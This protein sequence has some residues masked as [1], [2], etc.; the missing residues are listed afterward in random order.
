MAPAFGWL[1]W[2]NP[3]YYAFENLFTNEFS[4]L[5]LQCASPVPNVAGISEAF[6]SCAIRGAKPGKLSIDG[7]EYTNA[8]GFLLS[9]RWRNIGVLILISIVYLLVGIF[10]SEVM[11][12]TAGSPTITFVTHKQKKKKDDS[13][14]YND[15]EKSAMSS[16]SE[17]TSSEVHKSKKQ[18]E[19]AFTCT[20]VNVQIGDKEILR[21]ISFYVRRGELTAL[22]GA[23]G[24]GKTTLLSSL[25][26]VNFHGQLSGEVL[27]GNSAPG[28]GFRKT[29]GM[30]SS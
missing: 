8:Y 11:T 25:S 22:C 30:S 16:T 28:I 20:D 9:H 1:H 21:G 29:I 15:V 2:I 6:Q 17:M 3:M 24:A 23:S 5:N 4:G 12:F 18:R 10:G 7:A 13:A 19:L 27:V 14:V 26:Q